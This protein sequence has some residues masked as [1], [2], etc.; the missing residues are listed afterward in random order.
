MTSKKEQEPLYDFALQQKNPWTTQTIKEVYNNSWINISHREVLDPSGNS[1]IYG[2]VHF[3]N[4][5]VGV[6][7][8]GADHHT[9]LV[10]QYRYTLNAYS[11][12]IPEGGCLLGTDPLET[13]K[14]E[15]YEETGIAANKWSELL[16]IHTSNSVTDEY[17]VVYVA[18]DLTFGE[19]A[20]ESTEELVVKKISF[21]KVLELVMNGTITDS[22]TIAAVLKAKILYF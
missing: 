11:W 6:L 10:G 4:L 8:L 15:L 1:G 19:S 13:A 14:R 9:W 18:R 12:E 3:K 17:G 2:K 5:A 22:L 7:P 20:P 16:R 21:D